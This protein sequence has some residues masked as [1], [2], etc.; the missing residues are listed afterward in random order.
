M[1]ESLK[2]L[3]MAWNTK[4]GERVK[5]QHTYIVIALLLLIIAGLIGL[6]N[7]DLGQNILAVAIISAALFLINAVVW[8]LLQSAVLSRTMSRRTSATRKK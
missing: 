4:N 8:S 3:F 7:K 6:I 5:L 1:F 2:E